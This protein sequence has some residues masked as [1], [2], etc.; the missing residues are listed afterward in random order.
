MMD[1]GNLKLTSRSILHRTKS[2]SDKSCTENQN[3]HFVFSSIFLRHR[4]IDDNVEK[5]PE[6]GQGYR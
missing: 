2:V 3:T 1:G 6:E 4:A 5:Y